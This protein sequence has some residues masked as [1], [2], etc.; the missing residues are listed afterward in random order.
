MAS[1]TMDAEKFERGYAERY[2]LSLDDLREFRTVRPCVCNSE[3]CEGWQSMSH[4]MAVEYD[5]HKADGVLPEH[6]W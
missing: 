5:R 4:G 2:G 1:Y 6:L 3:L